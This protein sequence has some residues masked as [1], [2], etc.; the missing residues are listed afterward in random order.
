MLHII[1]KAM[2][3]VCTETIEQG[4]CQEI[5]TARGE[6]ECCIY[7]QTRPR[8]LYFSYTQAQVVL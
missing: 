5:N 3:Q 1:L 2:P 6:A 7:L 8:V 4:A